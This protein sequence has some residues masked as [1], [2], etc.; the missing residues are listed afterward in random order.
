MGRRNITAPASRS[1][2]RPDGVENTGRHVHTRRHLKRWLGYG[3]GAVVLVLVGVLC[4][5]AALYLR[6]QGNIRTSDLNAG[7]SQPTAS[8]AD[9]DHDPL[10]ILIV[11]TDTRSG[12]DS[13]FGST[14]D[15]SGYG[16]SDVM[17]LM[18]LSADRKRVTMVSF[19]RD[20]MVAFPGCKDPQTGKVYPAESSIQ[21]N[22]ALSM[23]GPGC[24]VATINSFTG[25]TIDHFILADFNAVTELSKAVGGVDVCVDKAVN[26]PASGLNLPAGTSSIEG[27]QALAFLRTRHAFGDASDLSRIKAQQAFLGSLARK[28]KSENTL[29][30]LPKLYKIADIITQNLTVDKALANPAALVTFAGRLKSVDLDK[31]AF[32]TAPIMPDPADTN[33][34]VLNPTES[35]TLFSILRADGD[36]TAKQQPTQAPSSPTTPTQTAQQAAVAVAV[37]NASGAADRDQVFAQSLKASGY[38][39]ARSAGPFTVRPDTQVFYAPGSQADANAIAAKLGV[40]AE[41]VMQAG[42]I[43]GV[44]VVLGEDLASAT[45]VPAKQSSDSLVASTAGG[46]STCQQVN[47]LPR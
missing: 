19:P 23:A 47:N 34:V 17:I 18:N 2:A 9:D 37:V 22:S 12:N 6:L 1:S 32:V 20:L 8:A 38:A 31:V 28:V 35:D 3:A 33:R 11:G 13:K 44:Q 26:D 24:T 10:Q 4:T 7:L 14:A 21:L 39:E 40:S 25:L 29:N 16:N 5:S 27:D 36:V 42:S 41:N 45:S 43:S 46:A 15:S 30:D